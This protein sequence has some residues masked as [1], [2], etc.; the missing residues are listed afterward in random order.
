M[1]NVFEFQFAIGNMPIFAKN[2]EYYNAAFLDSSQLAFGLYSKEPEGFILISNMRDYEKI[3]EMVAL[4]TRLQKLSIV[5]IDKGNIAAV[6]DFSGNYEY[7]RLTGIRLEDIT[8][9]LALQ[10]A[11]YVKQK[12]TSSFARPYSVEIKENKIHSVK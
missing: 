9:N 11:T 1:K 12:R 3:Q 7:F 8:D 4:N 6:I 2:G 10:L 5:G